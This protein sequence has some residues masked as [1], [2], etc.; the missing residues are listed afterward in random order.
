[1]ERGGS[2]YDHGLRFKELRFH[3]RFLIVSMLVNRGDV[4]RDLTE[5]FEKF[6]VDSKS[7]FSVTLQSFF[8]FLSSNFFN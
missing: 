5:R 8:F 2:C 6:I 3:V 7:S 1:M 4:V